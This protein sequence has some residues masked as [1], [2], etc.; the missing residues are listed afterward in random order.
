MG[1]LA[2]R[3]TAAT[4]DSHGLTSLAAPASWLIN[5][6]GG[7]LTVSGTHVTPDTAMRVSTIWRCVE[8]LSWL[9]AYLPLKVLRAR[10]G[11]GAEIYRQHPHHRLLAQ[12]PNAWQTSFQWRQFGA[13]CELLRG[14]QY[15]VLDWG[16]DGYLRAIKPIHPDR[17]QVYVDQDGLPVYQV[18]EYP[19][20]RVVWLSR[21]EMHHKWTLSSNGYTGLSPIEQNRETIGLALGAEEYGA[22]L[23]SNGGH[24]SGVLTV[25]STLT[26]EAKKAART[27]W[28]EAHRGLG[29]AHKV[30]VL[31]SDVKFDS[32]SMSSRDAQ[33]IEMRKFSVEEICRI[34]GVP[35][36]LAQHT[37]PVTSWGTGV[38]QRFMAFMA[39]KID[40]MLVADEQAMQRDLFTPDEF[41]NVWPAYNR[42]ALLRTDLLTRYQA[43]AIGRQWGWLSVN[44][45]LEKEDENPVG[46]QG[47]VLLDPMNMQ[48][49]YID[50]SALL[51]RPGGNGQGDPAVAQQVA[52]FLQR[53][54]TDATPGAGGSIS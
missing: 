26:D 45:I 16:E 43:Y 39:T 29:N 46:P 28:E 10:E 4:V 37:S 53:A 25:P 5:A 3:I 50:P 30:A 14:N 7:S 11:G 48:R 9:R 33:W 38:E 32:I 8:L 6:M 2:R 41:D 20:G 47:D 22:R 18:R 40:P 49:I 54:L 23:M 44:R 17:V 24:V 31:P 35:P 13:L 34:Y 15:N 42:A 27:S 21:Y 12:Q 52:A 19:S 36:E 1:E 51:S